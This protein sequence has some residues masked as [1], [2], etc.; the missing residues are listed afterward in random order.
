[1]DEFDAF[2]QQL[3]SENL[4]RQ[5]HTALVADAREVLAAAA[6]ARV[7]GLIATADSPD[8]QA[9]RTMLANAGGGPVPA[10]LLVGIVPRPA[11]EHLLRRRVPDHLWREEPWQPQAVLPV[12]VSTRDGHRFGFFPIGPAPAA[13]E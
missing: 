9:V 4:L 5:H 6:E 3:D 13:D 7:A 12:V 2:Y 1:M 8:A 10:A 11:I